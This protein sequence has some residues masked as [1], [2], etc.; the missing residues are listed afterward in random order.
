[1]RRVLTF[2]CLIVLLAG[3]SHAFSSHPM[4]QLATLVDP[5]YAYETTG[6]FAWHMDS[7]L[8]G[9]T[10]SG[11]VM[12]QGWVL[13]TVGVSRIDL[14]VDG[15]YISTANI[16][17]PRDDVIEHYP[18]FAGTA[19]ASPG[20]TVGFLA[21]DYADGSHSLYLVATDAED[22]SATFGSRGFIVDNSVNPAPKGYVD[23]PMPNDTLTGPYP[24]YGWAIDE[25]GIDRIE[26]LVDGQVIEGAVLGTPRPDIY[27]AFPMYPESALSGFVLYLD[28][29]RVPNGLH[30]LAVRAYDPLGQSRELAERQVFFSNEPINAPPFG[31]IEWPLRDIMMEGQCDTECGGI[32]GP[33]PPDPKCY[34][35][36]N[37]VSGWTLDT[38]PRGDQGGVAYVELMVDGVLFF[39][40]RTDCYYNDVLDS[41]F[42][43]YG[44][45]RYDIQNLYPGYTN[46]PECGW[47]FWLD[48]GYLITQMG[49]VQGVHYLSVRSGDVED[50][51]T[52]IDDIPVYFKCIHGRNTG[53]EKLAALGYIDVPSA[54]QYVSGI[55]LTAGW[56]IDYNDVCAIHIYVDGIYMGDA[57]YGDVR[58]DVHDNIDFSDTG[59]LSGWHFALDTRPLAD[60][61]HDFVV[62]VEDCDED[63]RIL[64]ER[65]F[66]SDNNP[67]NP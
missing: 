11:I 63:I 54:Y 26:L 64:G 49:Y 35:P 24:V 42:H 21:S 48:V 10:V 65:R 44:L 19:S 27:H 1:M 67:S 28:T 29:N 41:Y 38:A 51:V 39:N 62:E 8:P 43:C 9:D 33:S 17:I 16:N 12:V 14:Y 66:I 45:P 59:L 13:S 7:P 2:S 23:N 56:A 5:D 3:L 55:V 37:F 32:D 52:I 6:P 58:Q 50:T 46:S 61:E 36:L 57:L 53:Q 18:E 60:G 15:I 25:N 22:Y 30:S 4:P 47:K 20:F 34:H 40:T 31:W